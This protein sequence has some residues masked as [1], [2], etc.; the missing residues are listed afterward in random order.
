MRATGV[1]DT[2]DLFMKK[3]LEKNVMVTFTILQN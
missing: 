2:W 3:G 1:E